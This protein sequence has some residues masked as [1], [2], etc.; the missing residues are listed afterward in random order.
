[1]IDFLD[2]QNTTLTCMSSTLFYV[3]LIKVR[4]RTTEKLSPPF[5]HDSTKTSKMARDEDI[6]LHESI[7]PSVGGLD[8]RDAEQDVPQDETVEPRQQDS[9]KTR[10][11]VL[12]GSS[13]LQLPIWGELTTCR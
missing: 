2:P 5:R 10:A 3:V 4:G 8:L 6:S 7:A 13:I 9:R 11:L 1:M 12:L